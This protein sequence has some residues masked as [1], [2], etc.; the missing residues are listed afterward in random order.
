VVLRT[1]RIGETLPRAQ[2][3]SVLA[4]RARTAI[5]VDFAWD[6]AVV[7]AGAAVR[8]I[9]RGLAV[10]FVRLTPSSLAELALLAVFAIPALLALSLDAELALLAVIVIVALGILGGAP[11]EKEDNG[12]QREHSRERTLRVTSHRALRKL[13]GE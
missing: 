12:K 7:L 13:D 9:L 11:R 8:A 10:V 2:T 1:V 5:A 6:A 3:F 4:L